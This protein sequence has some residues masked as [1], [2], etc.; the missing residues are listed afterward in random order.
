M[1]PV[2]VTQGPAF[3]LLLFEDQYLKTIFYLRIYSRC[4]Y[5]ES[6]V[7]LLGDSLPRWKSSSDSIPNLQKSS[8]PFFPANLHPNS[9]SSPT[10]TA[11]PSFSLALSRSLS[12]SDVTPN[13]SDSS[14]SNITIS[15]WCTCRGTGNQE[16]E[17]D[18]FH[19]DFTHNTCL[20]ES[21]DRVFLPLLWRPNLDTK[22]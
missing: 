5:S 18:A 11:S 1:L 9:Y 10:L 17:C 21:S 19:R 13:Y 8:L 16:P 15:L 20:S 14:P 12:G 22:P 7:S 2:I 4:C 3:F 6:S